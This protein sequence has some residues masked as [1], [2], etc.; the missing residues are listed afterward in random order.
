MDFLTRRS[1]GFLIAVV[2]VVIVGLAVGLAVG[3]RDTSPSDKSMVER[4]I[5]RIEKLL[6]ESP[7][8]SSLR[9]QLAAF[10]LEAGA[11]DEAVDQ[12]EY[13]LAQNDEFEMA[14]MILGAV[15]MD[16]E[17]YEDALEPYLRVVELNEDNPMRG[18]NK[19]LQR[20]QYDLG[21]IYIALGEPEKAIEPLRATSVAMSTDADSRYLLGVAYS[22][23]GQCNDAIE[24]LLKAIRFV[25]TFTEAYDELA[26]CYQEVGNATGAAYANGMV[27]YCNE[28]YEQAL[29]NLEAAVAGG[30]QFAEAHL[31]LAMTYEKVGQPED[32]IE[33]Y[34]AVL[35]LDPD[36]T[37]AGARLNQ[38][39]EQ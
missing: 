30:P 3:L 10:Y 32:A 37:L 24:W 17:K 19:Q 36:N 31:G 5:E 15:Y 23:M 11:Y 22:D 21:R 33:A 28:R 1:R 20:A 26:H 2:L 4:E 39:R 12:A 35:A 6:E 8:N 38:L 34:E 16:Q 9:V 18:L 13:L 25:P 27:D 29:D 14:Y 7:F